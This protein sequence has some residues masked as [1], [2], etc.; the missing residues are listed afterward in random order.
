MALPPEI[1]LARQPNENQIMPL[2]LEA[3]DDSISLSDG[4]DL[5]PGRDTAGDVSFRFHDFALPNNW[6]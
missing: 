6:V 1:Q 5:R 4:R 2:P 3:P